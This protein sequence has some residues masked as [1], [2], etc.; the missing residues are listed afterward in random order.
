MSQHEEE[1]DPLFDI[2][3]LP[4]SCSEQI[5]L[6]FRD[7]AQKVYA[8]IYRESAGGICV[9]VWQLQVMISMLK[10]RDV[11]LSAGTGSGKTLTFIL[12]LLADPI[13]FAMTISPL[14]RLQSAHVSYYDH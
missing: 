7:E 9:R 1:M 14:K 10:G 5:D 3:E 12:P 13:A 6:N 8:T 2:L 11:I 4:S